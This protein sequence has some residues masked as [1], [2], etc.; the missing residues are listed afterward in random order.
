MAGLFMLKVVAGVAYAWLFSRL[1]D[2]QAKVDT[3]R[4]FYQS[5]QETRW[6]LS[7]PAAF[8]TDLVTPRYEQDGG[9]LATQ[10]SLLNDLKEVLVIKFMAICNVFSGGRYYVN[11]IFFNYLVL[12]GIA[13]FGLLWARFFRMNRPTYMVAAI[14]LWPSVLFWSSGFHR[15][16]LLLLA[17]GALLWL[18]WRVSR[19]PN[20]A[21]V[22]GMA[23]VFLFLFLLRNYLALFVAI[24]M[25][26]AAVVYYRPQ[27]ARWILPG[28]IT[29][30]LVLLVAL[31]GLY[32]DYAFPH[33]LASRQ[34][35]FMG[36]QGGS[37]LTPVPLD[38]GWLSL[39][40]SLPEAFRRSFAS[41]LP[42]PGLKTNEWLSALENVVW[43]I[44]ILPAV[45]WCRKMVKTTSQKA[46][47]MLA[48][49][50]V[51]AV[52]IITGLTIPFVGAIARYKSIIW[53]LM[54]P[55]VV[56]WWYHLISKKRMGKA[57]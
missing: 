17:V 18:A 32:P 12:F 39:L 6:L 42:G 24:A 2:Y 56:F 46:W 25:V 14:A 10:N 5:Q 53:P 26:L 8:F 57:S 40:K 3:W 16:G 55:P 43:L 38:D 29:L 22:L 45:W 48:V 35:E 27:Q 37:L 52:G 15:D 33:L 54:A 23:V 1:P 50:L 4:Y 51:L 30:G 34:Q 44:C 28:A 7:D 36:L 21:N 31:G 47:A 11:L 49:S 19:Q 13:G 20:W 41:P 9:M